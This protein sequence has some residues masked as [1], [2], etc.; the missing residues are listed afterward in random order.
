MK[1]AE[2]LSIRKDIEMRISKLKRL[3]E[4]TVK[5]QEGDEPTE[6][7]EVLMEEL[8]GCLGQLE[9]YIYCINVTNTCIKDENGKTMTL[10]LAER[11]VLRKRIDVLQ[12]TFNQVS[13]LSNRFGRNEIKNVI[14]IDAKGLRREL[15]KYSQQYRELDM[16]IQILNF[17]HEL[18]ES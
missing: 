9:H 10:L 12:N 1:L 4:N 14:T 3:L 17:T 8:D 2:A 18:V 6:D 5:V 11:D 16:K 13:E 7:P 15:N